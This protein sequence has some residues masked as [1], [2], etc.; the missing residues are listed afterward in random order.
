MDDGVD[1]FGGRNGN[2]GFPGATGTSLNPGAQGLQGISGKNAPTM[3][4]SS[5]EPEPSIL[6]GGEIWLKII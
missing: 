6:T 5:F 2:R 4:I 3:F 1:G